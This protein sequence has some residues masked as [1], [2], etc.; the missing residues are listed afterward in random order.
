[1]SDLSLRISANSAKLQEGLKNANQQTNRFAKNTKKKTGAMS[2]GF[3]KLGDSVRSFADRATGGMASFVSTLTGGTKAF[4][5]ITV[6]TKA[7][8]VALVSTGIGAIIVAIGTAVAG[9]ISYFK[10][11]K[12][13]ANVFNK[14]M[15]GIKGVIADL[16]Q[17]LSS[18]GGAIVK[19][20][21]GD[22]KG[23]GEDAKAAFK[24][25]GSS[26][27]DS[28]KG[29]RDAAEQE[30]ELRKRQIAF[31]TR[32]ARLTA[33]IQELKKIT[34][35]REND[36]QERLSAAVKAQAKIKELTSERI[37]LKKMEIK[38]LEDEDALGDRS[39]ETQE[40]LQNLRRDVIN[41]EAKRDK[42]LKN[43]NGKYSSA[44]NAVEKQAES[45]ERV[46][47]EMQKQENLVTAISQVQVDT[48]QLKDME[49]ATR[50]FGDT[51]L[52]YTDLLG[53][54]FEGMQNA[55]TNAFDGTKNFFKSFWDF[56]SQFIA[57]MIAKLIAATIATLALAAA[58]SA[59]GLGGMGGF[60]G[61]IGKA[62]EILGTGNVAKGL[63]GLSGV[64]MAD[65]GI[66]TGETLATVGEY[67]GAKTNPEVIAPLDKLQGMMAQNQQAGKVEF[68]MHYDELKGVLQTGQAKESAF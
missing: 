64:F 10:N 46:T 30:N 37:E 32:E 45:S 20:F 65:G 31:I 2:R 7:F 13:G 27:K 68:K 48:S 49:T 58:L 47:A 28:W 62:G 40:K 15:G 36:A 52:E 57:G 41:A 44:K 43:I 21:K 63:Q 51:S 35:N 50:Q 11:T 14:V 4:K 59:L 29:G 25:L 17:R 9:L 6:A 60:F 26:L 33:D 67:P 5:G 39:L 61:S 66:A 22:F 23:A 38:Q 53:S 1:M 19:L 8:K 56:F 24:D 18:I 55:I 42:L 12:E 16:G 3:S 34:A 54:A